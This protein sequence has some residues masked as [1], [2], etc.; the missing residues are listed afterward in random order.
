MAVCADQRDPLDGP[1]K[2]EVGG[3]KPP[4]PTEK[5]AGQN[6]LS[7][8]V[9]H[10]D[11]GG[12]PHRFRGKTAGATFLP[13]RPDG[14]RVESADSRPGRYA[15]W[16]AAMFVG[17]DGELAALEEFTARALRERVPVAAVLFG[18]PGTGKS[19]LL[20]EAATACPIRN[21]L[22]AAGYE[23]EREVAFAAVR[24]L[25][26][27]LADA[28]DEGRHLDAL[29]FGGTEGSIEPLQVFESVHR[30]LDHLDATLLLVDDLHWVDQSSLALLHYLVRS[31]EQE[32][33]PLAVLATTRSWPVGVSYANSLRRTLG[34]RFVSLELGP[35]DR[36]SG[37]RIVQELAPHLGPKDAAD[38]WER[39]EGIPFWMELLA[40]TEGSE[41]D[42]GRVITERLRG[43]TEDPAALLAVLVVAGR[44]LREEEAAVVKRWPLARSRA[45]VG[46]LVGAGLAVIEGDAV[47]PAHDLIRTAAAAQI[48]SSHRIE[49]HRRIAE[50]WEREAGGD[51]LVLLEALE[52]RH[53]GNLP[54]GELALRLVRSR[55]RRLLGREGVGRIVRIVARSDPSGA[56]TSDLQDEL[57]TLAVEL[58]DHRTALELWSALVERLPDP[59]ARAAVALGASRA[60][61]ELERREETWAYLERARTLA[62]GD[63]VLVM[64]A[65]ALEATVLRWMDHR[66]DE[67]RAV[68]ERAVPAGASGK[69][70]RMPPGTRRGYVHALGA[71]NHAA[72]QDD[73]PSRML[74]ISDEI[75]EAARGVDDLAYLRALTHGGYA[76][77]ALGRPAEADLRLRAAW[78][79]ARSSY[80]HSA[81][82]DAGFWLARSLLAWGY[83]LEAE[84]VAAEVATLGQRVGFTSRQIHNWLEGARLSR[85]NWEAAAEALRREASAERD[86]HFRLA[87]HLNVAAG[88]AR[89]DTSRARDEVL[90]RLDAG[91]ED[92]EAVACRRCWGELVLRG[93]EALARVGEQEASARWIE[94]WEGGHRPAYPV[95]AWW[96]RRVEASLA[97]AR[98]SDEALPALDAVAA[99]A[100]TLGFR[101]EAVW[102]GIDLAALVASSDRVRATDLLTEAADAAR[103]LGANTELRLAEQLLRGLGVR[104]W[105][106]GAASRGTEG[107]DHLSDR[108][109]Q[110]ARLVAAGASNPEIARTLFLSRKTVE[111]HVS[112]ILAKLDMRNRTELA[113]MLGASLGE[114]EPQGEGAPR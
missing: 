101:L 102:A 53:A 98:G 64:E 58:G 78:R 114:L 56:V 35:L 30:A 65:D 37:I 59:T 15:D 44:P 12:I 109:R 11:A 66:P 23:P 41:A 5:A 75:V 27:A 39:A 86:P 63:P 113:T 95:A 112:N 16:V 51:P 25:A 97:V 92:A 99:E 60:A 77:F 84:E 76:L 2:A 96:R 54:T 22:G 81:I 42:I 62:Q 85:G 45:A 13:V 40:S 46:E 34:A 94:D 91:R 52:H 7:V 24:D 29:L 68:A 38:V 104:T 49:L 19:R 14:S 67:A 83:V 72:L 31:A 17:R 79:G 107:L 20:A 103:S 47:R 106:R 90:S 93:A 105:R 73:D 50:L 70:D 111:R 28:S 61:Y 89:L 4:A 18:D 9:H 69:E 88:L 21:Q 33:Q 36:A 80:L 57:A 55:R 110:V 71:L 100:D 43:A 74:E 1:Y 87:L 26:R 6:Q 82:L 48:P 108:E 10:R 32:A 8:P 3:S